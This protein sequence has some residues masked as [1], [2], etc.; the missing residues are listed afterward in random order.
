MFTKRELEIMKLKKRGLTQIEIAKKLK[1]SQPSVSFFDNKIKRKI[2]DLQRGNKTIKKLKIK[3]D[4]E[5]DQD[6]KR[7]SK[8]ILLLIVLLGGFILINNYEG[9]TGFAIFKTSGIIRILADTTSPTITLNSSMVSNITTNIT[10]E[11][12][13]NFTD[14]DTG[15]VGN[16]TLDELNDS[17]T[18]KNLTYTAAGNQTV[19]LKI[20]KIANVTNATMNLSGPIN[21][22]TGQEWSSGAWSLEHD[23]RTGF[24]SAGPKVW[25]NVTDKINFSSARP[26]RLTEFYFLM[27]WINW[28]GG[29]G[30]SL[31]ITRICTAN[32]MSDDSCPVLLQNW[33]STE[34]VF[35][36]KARTI[37]SINSTSEI[38]YFEGGNLTSA[39]RIKYFYNS[40]LTNYNTHGLH[41]SCAEYD[42]GFILASLFFNESLLINN[43]YLEVGTVDGTHE[44]NH[45]GEFNGTNTTNDFSSAINTYLST[46]SADSLGYCLVPLLFHSD[47]G[48]ILE[49][50]NINIT[51]YSNRSGEICIASDGVCDT[52]WTIS[53]VTNTYNSSNSGG[54]CS[55]SW[56]TT[57]YDD[58]N[59][60]ISFRIKDVAGNNATVSKN[61]TLDRI[62]PTLTYVYP[63]DNGAFNINNT[64]ATTAN[65]TL[66]LTFSY[67]VN[68]LSSIANCSFIFNPKDHSSSFS[69]KSN[70]H[71]DIKKYLSKI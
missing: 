9:I 50:S 44:W 23:E 71:I 66:P 33:T 67:Y 19:Y 14:D 3:Y 34:L 12:W 27:Q 26:Y 13:A 63:G 8:L 48:G 65:T 59:Y 32:N 36:G 6:V 7:I 49:I 4:P 52:E 61:I 68:D 47:S 39:Q 58:A 24:C 20:L 11:L 60:N 35:N 40:S 41:F 43:P 53:N 56:N 5:N 31:Y 30:V 38:L 69:S 70:K 46:C 57:N 21:L 64:N 25:I 55:F 1:I 42:S 16:I 54:N 37:L 18:S 28:N 17:S 10:Y 62:A 22:T 45:S 2:R 51:Y 15:F 29:D